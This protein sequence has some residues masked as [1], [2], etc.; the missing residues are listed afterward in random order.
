MPSSKKPNVALYCNVISSELVIVRM[1]DKHVLW[2]DIRREIHAFMKRDLD[3]RAK[4]IT[5]IDA[6][7]GNQ[8]D[9]NDD[10]EAFDKVFSGSINGFKSFYLYAWNDDTKTFDLVRK[11]TI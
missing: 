6:L 1:P 8:D 3:V 7:T 2:T 11:P 10:R 4:D 9:P 5:S